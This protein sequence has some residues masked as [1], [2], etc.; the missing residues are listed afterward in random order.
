MSGRATRSAGLF[1]VLLLTCGLA[2]CTGNL[3]S[4]GWYTRHDQPGRLPA[5]TIENAPLAAD[6]VAV[7]PTYNIAPWL[8]FDLADPS[9][10]GF[11]IPALYLIS[12]RTNTGVFGDGMITV[13]MFRVDRDRNNKQVSTPMHAWDFTPEQVKMFRS[14]RRTALRGS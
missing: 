13:R 3:G 10:Q 4:E 14:V 5:E 1:G 8:R 11:K 9:P 2:G 7:L 6:V 12:S